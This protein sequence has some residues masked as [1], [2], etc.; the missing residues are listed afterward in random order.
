VKSTNILVRSVGNYSK[1]GGLIALIGAGLDCNSPM[2]SGGTSVR[3]V[4]FPKALTQQWVNH[5]NIDT[6]LFPY[7]AT[8]GRMNTYVA[9]ITNGA[10]PG[11]QNPSGLGEAFVA[12][13]AA[14]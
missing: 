11:F 8:D 9:G 5:G 14:Q 3:T 2:S 7:V 10:S 12:K 1:T 4:A 13:F 6:P